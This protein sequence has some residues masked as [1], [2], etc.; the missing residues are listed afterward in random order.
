[1]MSHRCGWWSEAQFS[2][3]LGFC[4]TRTYR[5]GTCVRVLC[6]RAVVFVPIHDNA[7]GCHLLR[8]PREFHVQSSKRGRTRTSLPLVSVLGVRYIDLNLKIINF[9][10]KIMASRFFHYLPT[11]SNSLQGLF[12]NILYND[13][14]NMV[15]WIIIISMMFKQSPIPSM[16][17]MIF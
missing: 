16:K 7:H 15:I 11:N 4:W 10:L 6:A 2:L 14:K 13:L 5:T 12:P 8:R 3:T 1:M 17:L 9:V